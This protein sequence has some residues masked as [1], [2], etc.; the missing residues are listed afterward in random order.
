MHMHSKTLF[1]FV[2]ALMLIAGVVYAQRSGSSLTT[3]DLVEIQQLYARYNHTLDS[4]VAEGMGWART[5][6]ADGEF[7]VAKA[8]GHA[9][10]AEFAK[11]FHAKSPA[12][13]HWNTNLMIT[14]SPG[15]ASG[16]VYLLMV[17]AGGE[18]KPPTIRTAATYVDD[19]VKTSEGWRFKKRTIVG[20]TMPEPRNLTSQQ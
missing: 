14:P 9:A 6:T 5:W 19:L 18:G 10:L 20:G 8:T 11:G 2:V 7:P 13:R 3:Q 1:T 16:S 4:G 17:D 12:L 15:G